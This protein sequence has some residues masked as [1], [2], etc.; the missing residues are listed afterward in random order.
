[1]MVRKVKAVVLQPRL[2]YMW[3]SGMR[4]QA[5]E[6]MLFLADE[7]NQAGMQTHIAAGAYRTEGGVSELATGLPGQREKVN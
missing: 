3:G 4:M 5:W 1:M 6:V 2:K 7:A